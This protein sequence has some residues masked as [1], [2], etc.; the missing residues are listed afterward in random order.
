MTPRTWVWWWRRWWCG[1]RSRKS[2]RGV[3]EP[4]SLPASLIAG[5]EALSCLG[6]RDAAVAFSASQCH[7]KKD[8]RTEERVA[9]AK[10]QRSQGG[11]ETTCE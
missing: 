2:D 11:A 3:D 8:P 6:R 7:T 5:F 4:M 10:E 9:K 1:Q